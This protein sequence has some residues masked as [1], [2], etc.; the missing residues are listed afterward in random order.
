MRQGRDRATDRLK[1]RLHGLGVGL[2][3]DEGNSGRC[4]RPFNK[5]GLREGGLDLVRVST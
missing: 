2:R 3:H 4:D 1:V 5:G